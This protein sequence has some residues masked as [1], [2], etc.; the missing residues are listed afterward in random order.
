MQ[1]PSLPLVPESWMEMYTEVPVLCFTRK[2]VSRKTLETLVHPEV[3][4]DD[5]A[6]SGD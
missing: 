1:E 6:A 4:P 2:V 5:L 3:A